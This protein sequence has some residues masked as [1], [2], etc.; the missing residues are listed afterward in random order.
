MWD[1]D[2]TTDE[3]IDQTTV[4]YQGAWPITF[5]AGY[6][7]VECR[8]MT[9]EAALAGAEHELDAH[10]GQA[11]LLRRKHVVGNLTQHHRHVAALL[12]DRNAETGE[13]AEREA[14]VRAS[15]FLQ[16]ALAPLRGDAFH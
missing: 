10:I 7:D 4:R 5:H 11:K 6:F 16:L 13:I 12:E 15:F 14:E 2:V 1:R 8:A 9:A 3:L